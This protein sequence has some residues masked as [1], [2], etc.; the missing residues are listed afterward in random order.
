MGGKKRTVEYSD[1][2]GAGNPARVKT[3]SLGF[4]PKSMLHEKLKRLF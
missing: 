4:L 2:D 3:I 1:V